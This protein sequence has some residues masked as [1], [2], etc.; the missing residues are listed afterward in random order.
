MVG[1]MKTTLTISDAV[2]DELRK[3]AQRTGKT[4]SELV[5]TALRNLLSEST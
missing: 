1:Q 5:E 3:T 2:M 4:I